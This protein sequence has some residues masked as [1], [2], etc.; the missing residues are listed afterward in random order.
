M[1]A[2]GALSSIE[3]DHKSIDLDTKRQYASIFGDQEEVSACATVPTSATPSQALR[4]EVNGLSE[5]VF[6]M[7]KTRPGVAGCIVGLRD[8]TKSMRLPKENDYQAFT[9]GSSYV[10]KTKEPI[11]W[12]RAD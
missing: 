3:V 4:I 7:L 11:K 2:S 5:T 8:A 1:V 6:P 12:G 10:G 9:R